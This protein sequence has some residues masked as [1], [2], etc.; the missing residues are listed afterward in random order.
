[1][2]N[3]LFKRMCGKIDYSTYGTIQKSLFASTY[4]ILLVRLLLTNRYPE[5]VTPMD[6]LSYSTFFSSILMSIDSGR[7]TNNITEIKKLYN[8]FINNYNRLNKIFALNNS[9]EIYTMF[10]YLADRGYLSKNRELLF[11]IDNVKDLFELE[12]A[13]IL[14]GKGVCRHRAAMLA[15]ILNDY[16]ID[17]GVLGVCTNDY[18]V[19][20]GVLDQPKYTREELVQ[21]VESHIVD[22]NIY[23]TLMEN[24]ELAAIFGANIEIETVVTKPHSL[25]ERLSGNHA[26]CFAYQ[27]GKN[28]FLDPTQIK[29]YR[30]SDTNKK[31]IC[32]DLR[33][34]NIKIFPSIMFNSF[35]EYLKMRRNILEQNPTVSKEE[36]KEMNMEILNLCN[37]N[38]DIFEKFYN[39]NKELYDEVSD[40]LSNI[41]R[42]KTLIR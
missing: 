11:S 15:D 29:V 22:K 3:N 17:A 5:V 36:E 13:E 1:M 20:I 2:E 28:Y 32:D 42:I 10:Y 6:T 35:S 7:Y 8:E 26:I 14:T 33:D 25:F 39:D 18:D 30:M 41:K 23:D 38:L 21:W 37:N 12:G 40:K 34:I 24:I 9:I 4:G 19:K 31:V 16:K 27:N